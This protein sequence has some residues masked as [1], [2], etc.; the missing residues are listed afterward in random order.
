MKNIYSSIDIGSDTIKLVV[1][2]LYKNKL[3]LLAA[4]SIKSKGIKKGLI[5]DAN[6]A[7]ASIKEA[8]DEV[9]T[10]LG[11]KVRRVIASIPSYFAEFKLVKGT[12]NLDHP[13]NDLILGD[14]I[15]KLFKKL[16]TNQINPSSEMIAILPI[17]FTVDDHEPVRDPKG[18]L[19][20][21]LSARAILVT[22]PRKN[23]LSVVNILESIGVEVDD[24][25]ISGIGDVYAFKNKQIDEQVGAIINIGYETTNVSLYNK[26]II[27]KNSIIG[28][29]GQNIDNDLSYIYKLSL[30]E[31][32]KVKEKLALA[33]KLYANVNETLT[34]RNVM[35]DD[36][37][38]NQFEASQIVMSR[39]AEIL[40]LA[41]RE[42]NILTNHK[43]D[44]IIVTGGVSNATHFNLV[45]D[46]VF[47]KGTI[48]GNVKLLGIRNNKYVTAL[49]NILY[50]LSKIRLKG[51]DY[52]MMS[53]DEIEYISKPQKN[54]I[55]SNDSML[56]KVFSYFFNE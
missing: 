53:E 16:I 48:V 1:C 45:A 30:P 41:K 15:S 40:D 6:L 18:M 31:S 19:G 3:N 38:I 37:A 12:I 11:V 43:P 56:G 2:E 26:G 33:H 36:V 21:S 9:E 7:K 50:F 39:I 13:E 22:T 52:S 24:V 47:G 55:I 49:G 32:I 14:D 34:V 8:F 51:K 35:N 10:I 25:S 46:E 42:L 27:V 20:K 4:S 17:D 29:G 23:L 54:N 44:Y 28:L 5:T